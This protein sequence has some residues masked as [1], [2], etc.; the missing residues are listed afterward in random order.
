[1]SPLAAPRPSAPYWAAA[2]TKIEKRVR[3]MISAEIAR[4]PLLYPLGRQF[5]VEVNI[6]EGS[7]TDEGGA[8]LLDLIGETQAVAELIARLR[9]EGAEVAEDIGTET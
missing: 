3:Y 5:G 2:V 4:R 9:A 8:L 6:R 7:M 1:M